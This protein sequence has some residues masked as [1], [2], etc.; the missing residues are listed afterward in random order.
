MNIVLL[1]KNESLFLW[2]ALKQGGQISNKIFILTKKTK[3]QIKYYGIC[4]SIYL[5]IY[6][7][8]QLRLSL[9]NEIIPFDP[10]RNNAAAKQSIVMEQGT[11]KLVS[12][13]FH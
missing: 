10:R 9:H 1:N 2:G 6:F 3:R 11:H 5:N 8:V 7:I 13:R 4:S 12:N